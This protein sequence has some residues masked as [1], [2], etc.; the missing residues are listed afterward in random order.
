M[1]V[2]TRITTKLTTVVN[3]ILTV[4]VAVFSIATLMMK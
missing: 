3:L 2:K 1:F 4:P